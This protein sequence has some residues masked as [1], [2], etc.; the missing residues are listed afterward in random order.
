M[1]FVRTI[2]VRDANGDEFTVYEFRD[3]RLLRKVRRMK[4]DTGEL[5]HLVN[6]TL[7]IAETGE[8]LV[9]ITEG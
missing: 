1:G 6:G 9:R 5:V 2:P 4:L 8:K 3:R 7:V